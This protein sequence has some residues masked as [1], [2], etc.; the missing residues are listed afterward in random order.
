MKPDEAS[1]ERISLDFCFA[2]KAAAC[3]YLSNPALAGIVGA[4]RP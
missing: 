2:R 3:P 1:V 4:L